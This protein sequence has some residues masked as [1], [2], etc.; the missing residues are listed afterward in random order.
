MAIGVDRL[1]LLSG[2][3]V[4]K[5]EKDWE[6]KLS[7][8]YRNNVLYANGVWT[9]DH[10]HEADAYGITITRVPRSFFQHVRPCGLCSTANNCFVF[11]SI[12]FISANM[13]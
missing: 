9:R 5:T 4:N 3:M 6:L 12:L 8:R 13:R 11:L 2:H 10:T 1:L 7:A